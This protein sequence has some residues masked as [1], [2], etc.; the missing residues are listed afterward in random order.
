MKILVS[1]KFRTAKN[2]FK[3]GGTMGL[4]REKGL[5]GFIPKALSNG[6]MYFQ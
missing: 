6:F 2:Y 3:E 1:E 4:R 5:P